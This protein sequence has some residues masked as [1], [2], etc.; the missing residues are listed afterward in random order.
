[1]VMI[2]S[3]VGS[4][5]HHRIRLKRLFLKL[6]QQRNVV[7]SNQAI[8]EYLFRILSKYQNG[9]KV[10]KS[11]LLNH[12]QE[13]TGLSRKHLIR[14]LSR[15]PDEVG[16]RRGSGRPQRYDKKELLPHIVHIW[17]HAEQVKGERLKVA[18]TEWLDY[19]PE[20]PQFYKMQLRAMSASTLNR[21]LK[22]YLIVSDVKK[23][24]A[25]TSPARHMKNKV[26]ISTLDSRIKEPGY[27]QADTVAHCGNTLLG[28]FI[29]SLTVTDI[30]TAWTENRATYT[31][32]AD[33]IVGAFKSVEKTLPFSLKSLNTDSGSEFLNKPLLKFTNFGQR[34]KF[35]RS[36]PYKKNDNCY[37]E[38]KNFTHVRELFGYE[39][40]DEEYLV[41][42]MN[43]IY[44]NYW[45]PL[46]NFFI[47]TYKLKEKIR[48]GGKIKKKYFKP[49]TPFKRL[50]LSNN[51]TEREKQ[52]L[53]D[54]KNQLNPFGLKQGL[55]EKLKEFFECVKKTKFR[56]I[57]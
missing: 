53:L 21:Y 46:Q 42:L 36:R 4:L 35:T 9:A 5:I 50:M 34:I 38:Q 31:K 1:L 25:S 12:A 40:L 17:K 13:V 49:M 48:I 51:L 27:V 7:M 45:N 15:P 39:R 33:Q 26:P 8:T 32:R 29:S 10:E 16:R 3:L 41:E 23:G 2:D 30:F 44:I 54:R 6:T 57:A 19:Y 20:C 24:I 37:V 14:R 22:E 28:S 55:E 43:D 47:P 56:N 52:E 18:V 11:R